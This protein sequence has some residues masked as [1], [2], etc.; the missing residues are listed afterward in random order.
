MASLPFIRV[1]NSSVTPFLVE[2][3]EHRIKSCLATAFSAT[4]LSDAA[5]QD[6]TVSC[7]PVLRKKHIRER[8]LAI[9]RQSHRSKGTGGLFAHNLAL[10]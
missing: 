9:L 10:V 6:L 5:I 8:F 1:E 2:Q 3:D 4:H 7:A